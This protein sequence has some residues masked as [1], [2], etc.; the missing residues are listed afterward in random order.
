[1]TEPFYDPD[2]PALEGQRRLAA[3]RAHLTASQANS[4]AAALEAH[5]AVSG[6]LRVAHGGLF[7]GATGQGMAA[8][9]AGWNVRVGDGVG[10][11][12]D[13]VRLGGVDFESQGAGAV[14]PVPHRADLTS[15]HSPPG[16]MRTEHPL[17][18]LHEGR[19]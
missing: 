10:A 8:E 19:G 11:G 7:A 6:R 18:R 16:Y 12:R 2:D 14:G 4:T 5:A 15:L 13:L 3:Q 1:M 9:V 17:K